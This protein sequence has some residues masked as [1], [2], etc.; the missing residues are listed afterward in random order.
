MARH[1]ISGR[2]FFVFAA[3]KMDM[4]GITLSDSE[5]YTSNRSPFPPNDYFAI[6][7]SHRLRSKAGWMP[8][9][10][11]DGASTD[12]DATPECIR[13]IEVTGRR[14]RHS[15]MSMVLLTALDHR[16]LGPKR[17]GSQRPYPHQFPFF[18]SWLKMAPSPP[19]DGRIQPSRYD[20]YH[21][22]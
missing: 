19:Q 8:A 18:F 17:G 7:A 15:R 5:K 11:R 21:K 1:K 4:A 10:R 22:V 16:P 3:L 13:Q 14:L 12:F 9:L 6:A 2:H 20:L